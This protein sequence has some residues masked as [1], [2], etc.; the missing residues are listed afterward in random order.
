MTNLT[1]CIRS[2]VSGLALIAFIGTSALCAQEVDQSDP[3]LIFNKLCY[4]QVPAVT[5]IRTLA[6]QMAFPS[7]GGDDLKRFTPLENPKLLEGW[8]VKLG[9]RL[10]RLG[11]VQSELPE[12]AKATFA[13]FAD[14][15]STSCSLILD[16]E[17]DA[18]LVLERMNA[19]TGKQPSSTDVPEGELLSTSWS[20]GNE[21]FKVFA[22]MK[23]N[24]EGKTNLL[25]VT[26]FSKE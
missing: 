21:D 6:N 4:S 10:Y 15:T 5:S 9:K 2:S 25:N 14:G 17:D 26:I 12:S 19:L 13:E 20:G 22:F 8:D 11:V 24:T 7:I 3:V 23:S 16:G 18:S 1:S